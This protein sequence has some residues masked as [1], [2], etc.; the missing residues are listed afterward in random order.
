VSTDLLGGPLALPVAVAFCPSPPLLPPV[1][2]GGAAAETAGLRSA[3]RAAVAAVLAVGPEV[4]VVLGDGGP[5]GVRYGAGD[6]GDLRG[7]GVGLEVPF[8]GAARPGG[9]RVPLAHTLGAWLLDD[10]GHTGTRLGIGPADL[11]A[12]LREADGP[13]GVLAM[14][15]GSARRTVKAP[16]YVDPAAEP[17]DAAVAAAVERGDAA[18]LAALDPAEGARLLA[19]GVPTWRAVGAALTGRRIEARLRAAEAPYGVGYLVADW[20]AA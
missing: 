12:V 18:A 2:A 7:F 14:G 4:V 19:G 15:D 16:G 10:A 9:R 17:F 1:V 3:C 13:V 20:Y 6:V 5:D 11:A 8:S